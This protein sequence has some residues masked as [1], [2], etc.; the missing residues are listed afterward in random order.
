[1]AGTSWRSL[2]PGHATVV[3]YLALFVALGG[4]SYAALK[5]GSGQIAD[6]SVRS[7]DI[8][9][10][11]VRGKDVRKD[12][13]TG[14]DVN[15]SRL[16][17]VPRAAAAD[18]ARGVAD[19]SVNGSKVVNNSLSGIDIVESQ[20][21]AV[22]L[23]TTASIA[24]DI[25]DGVV[26]ADKVPP[27]ALGGEDVD[28]TTLA[29]VDAA[30]LGGRSA[31]FF[32][33]RTSFGTLGHPF[34]FNVPGFGQLTTECTASTTQ[35]HYLNNTGLGKEIFM[36]VGGSDAVYSQRPNGMGLSSGANGAPAPAAERVIWETSQVLVI[37]TSVRT[38][39]SACRMFGTAYYAAG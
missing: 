4:S 8:R 23:A 7:K 1:M 21:G 39:P 22:P 28:E 5:V 19:N 31:S 35:W 25:E 3:A 34:T 38:A 20:L 9:N 15:E 30:T 24:E 26:T 14:A 2:R 29:G 33:H 6:N 32:T 13:L 27:N 17:T 10:N 37:T 12:T 16:G 18:L 36:D 11:N